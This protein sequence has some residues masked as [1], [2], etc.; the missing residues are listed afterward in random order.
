MTCDACLEM[1]SFSVIFSIMA[2]ARTGAYFLMTLKCDVAAES[3][4][5]TSPLMTSKMASW[6]SGWPYTW[7]VP[8]SGELEQNAANKLLELEDNNKY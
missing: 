4:M 6:T 8:Q 7:N 2:L 3:R 5:S 1:V